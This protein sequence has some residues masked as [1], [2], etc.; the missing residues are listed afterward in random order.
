MSVKPADSG[1]R[2]PLRSSNFPI[3]IVLRKSPCSYHFNI[4]YSILI[5]MF[6]VSSSIQRIIY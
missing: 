5:F 2:G 3:P 4:L 1:D 6:I